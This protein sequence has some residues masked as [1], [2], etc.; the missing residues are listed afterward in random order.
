MFNAQAEKLSVV[1]GNVLIVGVDIAKKK[2]VARFIDAHGFEL[3][4]KFTFRND[5]A[6]MHSFVREIRGL[7][8]R[9]GAERTVI[10][11]EP[12]G[13]YWEP[14]AYFLKEY[15]MVLVF[16]NPYH[17][18]RSKEMDDNSPGKNDPKDAMLVAKLVKEGRYFE[19]YLPEGM[20]RELRNLTYERYQQRKKLNNAKNRLMALLDRYFPEFVQA[21]KGPLGKTAVFILKFYPFPAD[22]IKL[23]EEE[24]TAMIKK[25]SSKRLGEKK[26]KQLKLI[27][28]YSIGV[29]EGLE[30]ARY[31]L[32]SC[33][34]EIEFFQRQMRLTEEKMSEQLSKTGF[35]S[36]LLS[37]PGI[38]VVTA[39]RF[40]GEVGDI[41]RFKHPDQI[42]KLAGYNL[43]SSSSGEKT[44]ETKITKRG[45]S[46]LRSLLYQAALVAV[47]RNPQLKSL[48]Q[49]YRTRNENPLKSK[50][51]LVVIANKLIR[52]M[53]TLI[54]KN[55]YYDPSLVLGE[56]RETQLKGVA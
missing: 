27:A 37:I 55:A 36:N 51:A 21:F 45:R 18:K 11:M 23:T 3:C 5:H 54:K 22:I 52:I 20:Y 26:A 13:H 47:S 9:I 6:G 43:K 17:V 39:A 32:K 53:F 30:S 10:G 35:K 34:E 56:Y 41:S 1:T 24:L 38:G 48:Y 16:V 2:N 14:L 31:R 4:K 42:I 46:E 12:T 15:P 25:A 49:Y 40:M 7:E 19:V 44:G 28:S 8:Q 29:Q 33:L 50:Q